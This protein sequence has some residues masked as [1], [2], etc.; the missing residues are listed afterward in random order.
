[1]TITTPDRIID[2]AKTCLLGDGYAGMSTRRVAD[3]AGVPLSQIHY[4]FGSKQALILGLLK[5]ENE[6]LLGRQS[7]MFDR[8]LPFWQRWDLACDYLDDD[9]DSG[10]V[11]VLQEMIAA[12]WSDPDIAAE[13][14][15][16]LD[17]W[18]QL[19]RRVVDE[20]HEQLGGLGPFTTAEIVALIESVFLGAEAVILLGRETQG[21][22]IRSALRTIG[23]VIK[24]FEE[25]GWT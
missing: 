8:P 4:H 13:V 24:S 20:G 5:S 16:M 19:L 22:P 17:G 10:Y 7:T 18:S 11:R 9:I 14:R 3:E 15:T 25:G 1:M 23:R 12:G 2:A 6:R 21:I